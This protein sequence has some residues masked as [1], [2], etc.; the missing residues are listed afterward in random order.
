MNKLRWLL[1][2]ALALALAVATL[3]TL[4][5]T[6]K[7]EA[8][9]QILLKRPQLE[10]AGGASEESKN[11]WVWV[12]DGMELRHHLVSEDVLAAVAQEI[13]A[14]GHVA[15]AD[16]LRSLVSVH[17]SGGD[18]NLFTIKITDTSSERAITAAAAF[19]RLFP[20]L[21][22]GERQQSLAES[23]KALESTTSGSESERERRAEIL[24][25]LRSD[26][27]FAE[28]ENQRRIVVIERPGGTKKVW[29]RPF[30]IFATSAV[31]ALFLAC[32]VA[33]T[34]RF[35]RS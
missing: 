30:F 15:T 12:R 26:L 6:P 16:E 2:G 29:P 5:A 34:L 13:S 22:I 27:V 4:S 35:N 18:D 31:A 23:I 19:L 1:L 7:Y 20:N 3:V 25:T 17:Y 11:R 33:V 10:R 24:A 32:L 28:A 9:A 8:S 14:A 21:A